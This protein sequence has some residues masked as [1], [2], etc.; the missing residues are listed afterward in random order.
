MTAHIN[1]QNKQVMPEQAKPALKAVD[2]PQKDIKEEQITVRAI[3]SAKAKK[4][5]T[6]TETEASQVNKP[7]E[8]AEEKETS[9]QN[10]DNAV[11]QLNTYVQSINRNL[12]FNIDNDS[13]Q[14]V[15][16]VIDAETDELIRQ[17]PNEEALHI[18]KQLNEG[19]D[20]DPKNPIA[21]RPKPLP[22][23]IQKPRPQIS[24]EETSQFIPFKFDYFAKNCIKESGLKNQQII[25]NGR[26]AST[27]LI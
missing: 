18:A 7:K 24:R 17:I 6:E 2:H 23:G 16:K 15:V 12:E 13:G 27:A 20:N 9:K 4:T 26:W 22:L 14:T 10:L 11:K 1:I 21:D 25:L 19:L 8:T 3:E 5:E